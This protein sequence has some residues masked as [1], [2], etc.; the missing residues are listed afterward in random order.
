M[1][2]TMFSGVMTS[3]L[4]YFEKLLPSAWSLSKKSSILLVLLKINFL[5]NTSKLDF[6]T[7]DKK[8]ED[9]LKIGYPLEFGVYGVGFW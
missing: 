4:E 1:S 6:R 7:A 3:E 2:F 5:L 9:T 8:I